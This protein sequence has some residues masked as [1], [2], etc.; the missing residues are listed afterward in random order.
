MERAR[1]AP[2]EAKAA[3]KKLFREHAENFAENWTLLA[4]QSGI[5]PKLRAYVPSDIPR[6][7]K[8]SK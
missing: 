2:E 3:R 5:L 1:K 8:E 4:Q 6:A 7:A